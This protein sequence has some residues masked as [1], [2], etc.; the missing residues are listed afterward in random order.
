MC[1]W[2]ISQLIAGEIYVPDPLLFIANL[3]ITFLI[4][5]LSIYCIEQVC[6]RREDEHYE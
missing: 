3:F 4:L 5:F 6:I 1:W 2:F